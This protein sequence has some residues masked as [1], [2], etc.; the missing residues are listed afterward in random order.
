M[1]VVCVRVPVVCM[2]VCLC[3]S[4]PFES[5]NGGEAGGNVL[6]DGCRDHLMSALCTHTGIP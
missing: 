4:W 5:E 3:V 6:Y 1:P 2:C